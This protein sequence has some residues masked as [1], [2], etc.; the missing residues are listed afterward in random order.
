M[1]KNFGLLKLKIL[2][3]KQ[4]L[5]MCRYIYLY[6]KRNLYIY[7]LKGLNTLDVKFKLECKIM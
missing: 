5:C 3:F 7:M 6:C 4:M 2:Y 1:N